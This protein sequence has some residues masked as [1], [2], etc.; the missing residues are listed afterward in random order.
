MPSISR[1]KTEVKLGEHP[2]IEGELLKVFNMM[3]NGR[4]SHGHS[5]GR[6]SYTQGGRSG[7]RGFG[8]QRPAEQKGVDSPLPF[9]T[10]SGSNKDNK[11]IE[12]LRLFGEYCDVN[13]KSS[14]GAAFSSVPPAFGPFD[15][16]PII[17][18]PV[19]ETPLSMIVVQEYLHLK[20][21]WITEKRTAEL[22]RLST[23]SLL[24]SRLSE[25]SR[26]ELTE[27][28]HWEEKFKAKDLLYLISRIRSTHIS[29]T[30][31]NPAQDKERTRRIWADMFMNPSESSFAFRTRIENHQ[32]ERQAVG[33]A[34]I[35]DDELII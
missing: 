4:G 25:S 35:P 31:G 13:M 3:F 5:G 1:A 17:P 32:L 28:E 23:F 20:K 29:Q 26:S 34:K 8:H 15:I 33:L 18:V 6:T 12:F 27:H 11:S 9:L 10:W 2:T 14:I 24:W 30:S 7:G 22:Q 21:F 19:G 16:E